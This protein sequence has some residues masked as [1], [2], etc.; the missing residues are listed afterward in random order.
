MN[1]YIEPF[2]EACTCVFESFLGCEVIPESPYPFDKNAKHEWDISG[3]IGVTGDARGTMVISMKKDL[4]F[5]LAGKLTGK[6]YTQLNDDVADTIGEIVNIIS[7]NAKRGLEKMFRL[8]I[9]LP[10]IVRGK[11][12]SIAWATGQT[13]IL[14]IPFTIFENDQFTLSITLEKK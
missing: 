7:G 11:G 13:N 6:T 5:K 14:S 9:S 2:I 10:I 1:V 3:V 4:A 8:F 12:H